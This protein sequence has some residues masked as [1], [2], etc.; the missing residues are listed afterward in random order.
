[1]KTSQSTFPFYLV[2]ICLIVFSLC[3]TH[4]QVACPPQQN[5][6][7]AK[8][9]DRIHRKIPKRKLSTRTRS[10]NANKQS[11]KV[12]TIPAAKPTINYTDINPISSVEISLYTVTPEDFIASSEKGTST[13]PIDEITQ[14]SKNNVL[15]IESDPAVE[16]MDKKEQRKFKRE[17]RK[18]LK[19]N[20]R[21]AQNEVSQTPTKPAYGFAVAGFVTGLVSLLFIPALFGTLGI[22]FSA[23]ALSR[24]K[25]NPSQRGRGMAIAG[26]VLGIVGV[27]WAVLVYSGI[28]TPIIY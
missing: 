21:S 8:K 26:L 17:F 5:K 18:D 12:R 13:D 15:L 11:K 3:S 7:L 23:I 20:L 14:V 25:N 6:Y 27:F 10:L 1:M 9:I 4:K 16:L 22:I 24:L 28:I 2:L 19:K